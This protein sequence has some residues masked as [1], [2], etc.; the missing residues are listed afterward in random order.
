MKTKL[1]FSVI[2]LLI[3]SFSGYS[4]LKEGLTI[5]HQIKTTSVKNQS[6]T[7]TCWS[8]ATTS[9]IETE[10]LRKGGEVLDL[11]EMY[12]VYHAYLDK[13][14][15]FVRYQG[16]TNFGQG[17]QAHDVLKVIRTKGFVQEADFKGINYNKKYHDHTE[18]EQILDT[19]V[20]SIVK[21]K[22]PSSAWLSAFES[23]LKTYLGT[24]PEIIS[25]KNKVY[26]PLEFSK[27][28]NKINP[29]EY[30]EL[31]SFEYLPF[32][33]KVM[34]DVPDN[35][36]HDLYYNLP[37]DEL[38]QIMKNAL[39]NGYSVCWD[40]DMSEDEF[41]HEQGIAEYTEGIEITDVLRQKLF[42]NYQTTDDHLM[43]LTGLAK[44]NDGKLF[45]Q[46]KNSWSEYS[47]S[48][49]GYLYMSEDYVRLKTVAILLHKDAISKEIL[50]KLNVN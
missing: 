43:H 27:T 21:S 8:F 18:L 1:I 34:L 11:S 26:P 9:Y 4:Q 42:D 29:D 10:I 7:G 6:F 46:T 37:I 28:V 48:Y 15:K 25:Y 36:S 14:Q 22:N 33:Q 50:K 5:T 16:K 24:I 35:W 45:F 47:N 49:G 39:E 17:G 23:I 13:A 19:F 3:Y 41:S 32:Y 2:L 30:I 31:T 40:G 38:M 12:F 20:K 44:N